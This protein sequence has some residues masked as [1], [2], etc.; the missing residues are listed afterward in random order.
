M[1]LRGG[2]LGGVGGGRISSHW[3]QLLLYFPLELKK[4]LISGRSRPQTDPSVI[5]VGGVR[6]A[7]G[8]VWNHPL[9]QN[10]ETQ[11]VIVAPHEVHASYSK[12][13]GL[14]QA[15]GPNF[16]GNPSGSG[17]WTG[18]PAGGPSL[19]NLNYFPP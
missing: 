3:L 12:L 6:G 7:W 1:G 18:R 17:R 10:L 14:W 13:L 11:K 2:G 19:R 16:E 9:S 5:T 15:A 8:G 4:I